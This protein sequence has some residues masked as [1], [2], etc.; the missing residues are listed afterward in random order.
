MVDC[1][2]WHDPD[3]VQPAKP[4]W[5]TWRDGSRSSSGDYCELNVVDCDINASWD[6]E[7][8]PSGHGG[9]DSDTRRVTFVGLGNDPDVSVLGSGVPTTPEMAAS[10]E[11][12]LPPAL[13]TAPSGGQGVDDDG[14]EETT[15]DGNSE[16]DATDDEESTSDDEDTED[17]T[18]DDE[19]TD[20]NPG[21][22]RGG[23]MRNPRAC[24]SR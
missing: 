8:V 17:D 7:L 15:E 24:G 11:R 19:D 20:T 9:D 4:F 3:D 13:G 10:G 2:I 23:E 21:S 16:E 6:D 1:A 14:D 5:A 22:D 18:T 12:Q